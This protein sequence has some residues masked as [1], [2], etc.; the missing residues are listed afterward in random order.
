MDTGTFAALFFMSSH[1]PLAWAR[2]GTIVSCWGI[3]AELSAFPAMLTDLS[4]DSSP[5]PRVF[6]RESGY[7]ALIRL[8]RE[9]DSYLLMGP[10]F[11]TPVTEE[12]LRAYLKENAISLNRK[13]EVHTALSVIPPHTWHHFLGNVIFLEYALNGRVLSL[14]ADFHLSE[15]TFRDK[16]A[17]DQIETAFSMRDLQ[18]T[19]GTWDFELQIMELIRSGKP[20]ELEA[21][22]REAIST[23]SLNE[24]TVAQSPLR[25]A[26]NI[27]IAMVAQVGKN[28]AIPGGLDIEQTYQLIDLYSQECELL[29]SVEA[30][31]NLQY[32]MLLDFAG[33]VAEAKIPRGISP[34]VYACIQFINSH[35]NEPIRLQDV[36]DAIHRSPTYT[37]EHFKEELG[38]NVGEYITSARIQEAKSLLR[39]TD[40]KLSEISSYLCFSSQ[41]YFQNVFKKITGMTPMEYRNKALR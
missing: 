15:K 1:L 18:I 2:G 37:A 27:F 20:A 7:L 26:K 17:S 12:I 35:I 34:D 38:F 6:A 13:E 11:A 21:L 36:A 16:V 5:F 41:S 19:H 3:P 33:R 10:A 8:T 29:Q 40:R 30:V 14:V 39:C 32:N 24:G 28:A 31:E 9:E 22:L 25:Q 4:R 23:R